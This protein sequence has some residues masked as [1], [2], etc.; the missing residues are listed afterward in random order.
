MCLPKTDN[1]KWRRPHL[2]QAAV[3]Q[4]WAPSELLPFYWLIRYFCFNT[5]LRVLPNNC[6]VFV[7]S[8]GTLEKPEEMHDDWADQID[9]VLFEMWCVVEV[10]ERQKSVVTITWCSEDSLIQRNHAEWSLLQSLM[11]ARCID[12]NKDENNTIWNNPSTYHKRK[13]MRKLHFVQNIIGN[14][15]TWWRWYW[16]KVLPGGIILEKKSVP[17][18]FLWR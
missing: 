13:N 10:L 16:L 17:W 2:K 7:H 9:F 15:W 3:S 1:S 6:P 18:A 14:K 5:R 11:H 8:D 4:L 12:L